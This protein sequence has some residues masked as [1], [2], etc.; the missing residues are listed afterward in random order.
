MQKSPLQY[1]EI[2]FNIEKL[3][4]EVAILTVLVST[5]FRHVLSLTYKVKNLQYYPYKVWYTPYSIHFRMMEHG[6][7]WQKKWNNF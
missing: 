7:F 3:I 4:S 5:S 2:P 1:G 6:T